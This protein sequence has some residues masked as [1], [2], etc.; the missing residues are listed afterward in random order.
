MG[1][2]RYV[3]GPTGEAGP[4]V[5][6]SGR[7]ASMQWL[8]VSVTRVPRDSLADSQSRAEMCPHTGQG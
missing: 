5:R 2:S 7:Q 8:Q 4:C 6:R 1:G 3:V